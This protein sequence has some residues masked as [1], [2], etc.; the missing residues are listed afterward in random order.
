MSTSKHAM[1]DLDETRQMLQQSGEAWF[2][3][4]ATTRHFREQRDTLQ[5]VPSSQHWLS[6]T[7]LGWPGMLVPEQF[8]GSELP[9]SAASILLELSGQHLTPSPL[10]ATAFVAAKVLSTAIPNQYTADLL[11]G[12]ANGDVVFA[13]AIDDHNHHNP[14]RTVTTAMATSTGWSFHGEKVNVPGGNAATHFLV[15]AKR[16]STDEI[17]LFVVSASEVS[18]SSVKLIDS[19]DHANIT[20]DV[21]S[22]PHEALL[23]D[24]N[25]VSLAPFALSAARIGMATEMLGLGKAAFEM[26]LEY[27]KIREQFGQLIGSFQAIQHRCA[28]MHIELELLDSCLQAAQ[29]ALDSGDTHAAILACQAKA[30]AN[31]TL[32]LVTNETV[33]LHG[34][35]GMTDE[36]DAGLYIKR[37]RVCSQLFGSASYLRKRYADLVGF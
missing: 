37:A 7:E 8:G 18:C 12:I 34:G 29:R 28:Q 17:D 24:A 10:L 35:I 27:V 36:H 6:M 20:L 13:L 30:L 21:S 5:T 25:G 15:L 16:D 33:Q 23:L 32:E 14:E 4:S 31:E 3:D 9:F 1:N 19:Q 26:T 22:A 11:T 2:E